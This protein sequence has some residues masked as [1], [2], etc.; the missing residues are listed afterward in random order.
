MPSNF[1]NINQYMRNHKLGSFNILKESDE[2]FEDTDTPDSATDV[3]SWVPSFDD[4][5]IKGWTAQYEHQGALSWWNSDFE[6]VLVYATPGW[7]GQDGVAVEIHIDNKSGDDSRDFGGIPAFNQTLFTNNKMWRTPEGFTRLM[8]QLF[9]WIELQFLPKLR[10]DT[11]PKDSDLEEDKLSEWGAEDGPSPDDIDD[12]TRIMDLGGS[13]IEKGIISLLDDGFSNE[14]I[15][16]L[17]QKILLEQD[18]ASDEWHS[19]TDGHITWN[20]IA[21]R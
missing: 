13:T 17:V 18:M 3:R 8:F 4:K 7:E 5:N 10:R 16:E 12:S 20:E 11:K 15:L 9:G 2:R 21:E 19:N 6:D 1:F 14:D